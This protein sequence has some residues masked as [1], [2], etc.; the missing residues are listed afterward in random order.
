MNARQGSLS[1][2]ELPLSFI[3]FSFHPVQA[4]AAMGSTV[5][6][7]NRDTV[8]T[9]AVLS[10]LLTACLDQTCCRNPRAQTQFVSL[11]LR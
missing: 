8:L 7:M 11:F 2:K 10:I 9:V 4:E 1:G 3:M 6:D 5:L